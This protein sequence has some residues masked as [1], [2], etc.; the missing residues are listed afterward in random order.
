MSVKS[1]TVKL[2][3]PQF[4]YHLHHDRGI[5][6]SE[7]M[8]LKHKIHPGDIINLPEPLGGNWPVLGV[9]Y[10][11]G[12]PYNQVIISEN[13]WSSTFQGEGD[14]SLGV[15]LNDQADCSDLIQRM[16]KTY[17]LGPERIYNNNAMH[18]KAMIAFD[19]TFKVADT[20][21]KITLFI[22]V[23]GLFVSTVAGEVSRQKQVALLRCLGVSGREL[24]ILGA[25]QLL[26]IGL[27]T[28]FIALPLGI[29]VAQL[30]VDVVLKECFWLDY[31]NNF[32]A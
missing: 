5:M 9:Y 15:V 29:L 12:N 21:G 18:T 6:V 13:K 19:Q 24:V 17:S 25:L 16:E 30:M 22:A 26:A 8:S 31:A 4:W 23:F 10:D 20:L 27:F 3:V 7:S 32:I 11:Y 2:A 1:L 28:A 14:V